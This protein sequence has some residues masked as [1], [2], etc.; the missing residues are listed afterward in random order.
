MIQSD[1]GD[2][3]RCYY[4]LNDEIKRLERQSGTQVSI[5]NGGFGGHTGGGT[6]RSPAEELKKA[7]DRRSFC[8]EGEGTG[9]IL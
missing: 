6:G 7:P 9:A 8:P 2:L 3:L 5:G 4:Q 1:A